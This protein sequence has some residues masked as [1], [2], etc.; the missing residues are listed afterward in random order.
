MTDKTGPDISVV[1]PAYNEE[2]RLPSFLSELR[3]LIVQAPQKYEVI[4]VDD[5]STDNTV[6]L[7]QTVF[8]GFECFRAI[9]LKSNRGKGYAVRTGLL[10]A[11]GNV[12]VFMD[13][14]G[15]YAP[16]GIVGNLK[17]L[18]EGFD[19]VVGSRTLAGF[20]DSAS[21]GRFRSICSKY[22]NRLVKL[23]LKLSLSDT[24]CGFK[25][26]QTEKIKPILE[27]LRIDGFGFDVELMFLA[28]RHGLKIRETPVVCRETIGSRVHILRNICVMFVN[29]FQVRFAHSRRMGKY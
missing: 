8:S 10:Q 27:C 28:D 2:Q 25:M 24:Q 14:D 1:I 16:A 19:L 9:S 18:H 4:V 21:S 7:A 22:F 12:S 26:F 17:Y 13:A 20:Q 6:F 29:I 15:A 11:E 3:E 23:V 5:G